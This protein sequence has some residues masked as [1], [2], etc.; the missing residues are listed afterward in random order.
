MDTYVCD[1]VDA[2]MCNVMDIHVQCYDLVRSNRLD[3]HAEALLYCFKMLS[4]LMH[5][6]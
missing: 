2:H 5:C 6:L 1:V 3:V 4:C